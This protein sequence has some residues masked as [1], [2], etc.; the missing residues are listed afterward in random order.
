MYADEQSTRPKKKTTTT[1]YIANG[2]ADLVHKFRTPG[3]MERNVECL[4]SVYRCNHK[5]IGSFVALLLC[6]VEITWN[7]G[8]YLHCLRVKVFAY[9]V[10]NKKKKPTGIPTNRIYHNKNRRR[11]HI[12][13]VLFTFFIIIVGVETFDWMWSVR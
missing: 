11:L 1:P 8:P 2:F 12:L 4:L 10:K 13:W 3:R 5:Y 6:A 9:F 7:V